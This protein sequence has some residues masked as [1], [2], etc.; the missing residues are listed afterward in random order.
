MNKKSITI[1]VMCLIVSVLSVSLAYY[2]ARIIGDGSATKPYE[3]VT[4]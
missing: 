1:L 4:D 2:S 3:I